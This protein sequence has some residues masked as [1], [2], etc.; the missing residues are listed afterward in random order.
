MTPEQFEARDSLALGE[1]HFC[2][3]ED[4]E[5]E[6]C[7]R[8]AA[9]LEPEGS[10][11]TF[12]GTLYCMQ[13]LPG[14]RDSENFMWIEKAIAAFTEVAEHHTDEAI[15]ENA[16]RQLAAWIYLR[17]NSPQPFWSIRNPA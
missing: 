9:E 3:R 14:C 6:A 13:F 16:G 12:I 8:R 17:D 10:G 7:F 1:R 5:A 15:R 4:A 11:A 2:A